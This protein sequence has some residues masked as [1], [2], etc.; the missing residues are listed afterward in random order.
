MASP[1]TAMLVVSAIIL[2]RPVPKSYD[3]FPGH[4]AHFRGATVQSMIVLDSSAMLLAVC[5][6]VSSTTV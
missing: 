2:V 6:R 5:Q 3:Y 1:Q 4:R